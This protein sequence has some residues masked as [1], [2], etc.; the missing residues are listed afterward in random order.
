MYSRGLD[1]IIVIE[2]DHDE[3]DSGSTHQRHIPAR[4]V[5]L[6][7]KESP[8]YKR[9]RK[10]APTGGGTKKR[11]SQVLGP[12][13]AASMSPPQASEDTSVDGMLLEMLAGNK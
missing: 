13:S 10:P 12:P 1:D 7:P 2:F 3:D 5:T 9:K 8:A 4:L 11:K 6:M